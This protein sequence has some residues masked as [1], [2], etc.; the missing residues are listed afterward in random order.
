MS[1]ATVSRVLSSPDKVAARTREKVERAIGALNYVPHGAARS[2]AVRSQEAY[3]LVL[4]ELR[5]SYYADLLFGFESAASER[6]ASVV[7][8]LTL[9]KAHPDLDVR[10][11][12]GRVDALAVMGSV[13][14]PV[15]TI[16]A[17][18]RKVPV[19]GLATPELDGVESFGTESLASARALTE[20]VLAEHG[21]RQLLFVGSPELAPDVRERYAGFVEAHRAMDLEPLPPVPAGLDEACGEEVAA[22]VVAGELTADAL[23]CANDELALAILHGVVAAGVSVPEDLVITGWDDEKAARYV[24]PGL[25]TVRQPIHE[26]GRLV[27]ERLHTLLE[28]PGAPRPDHALRTSLVLRASCGCG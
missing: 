9:D 24:V 19:V 1:I 18:S 23:V 4:P 6:G 25:T 15:S 13:D 22:R 5:G 27:A 21:R 14:V 11:L 3:G 10:R 26:L 2:L 28:D 17:L 16:S 12:A 20:H 8:V 7:V